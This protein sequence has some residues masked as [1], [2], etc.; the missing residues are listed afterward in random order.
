LKSQ[1]RVEA[2]QQ[3]RHGFVRCLGNADARAAQ[4]AFQR[5]RAADVVDVLRRAAARR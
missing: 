1:L 2:A 5:F 4:L 3:H